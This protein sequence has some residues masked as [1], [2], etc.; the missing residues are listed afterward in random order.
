M[1]SVDAG[2]TFLAPEALAIHHRQAKDF[3]FG[4]RFFK[5]PPACWAG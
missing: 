5:L 1:A 2:L 4:K 3:D